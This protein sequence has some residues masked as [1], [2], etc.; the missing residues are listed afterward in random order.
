VYRPIAKAVWLGL[1]LSWLADVSPESLVC[2]E[3]LAQAALQRTPEADLALAITGDLD[4][5]AP[6]DKQGRV[7]LALAARGLTANGRL[8]AASLAVQLQA[9]ERGIRQAEAAQRLLQFAIDWLE[10]SADTSRTSTE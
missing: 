3:A 6:A 9:A 4:P 8:P 2:S 10:S 7:F 5:A 1:D